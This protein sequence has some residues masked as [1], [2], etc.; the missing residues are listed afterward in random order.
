[1]DGRAGSFRQRRS[2]VRLALRRLTASQG[3]SG[4]HLDV[5]IDQTTGVFLFVFVSY[6]SALIQLG[7]QSV[8]L[9]PMIAY[10]GWP[11]R[12]HHDHIMLQHIV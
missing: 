8:L 1:M 7:L 5:F 2:S 9:Q 11:E 12:E 10:K 6:L 4:H 3:N